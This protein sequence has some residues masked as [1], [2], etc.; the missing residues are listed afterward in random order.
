MAEAFQHERKINNVGLFYRELLA[1]FER[2]GFVTD[3]GREQF[4]VT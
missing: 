2:R 4:H 1:E 3:S